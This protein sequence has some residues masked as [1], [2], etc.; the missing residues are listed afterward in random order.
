MKS[1]K[2]FLFSPVRLQ[3]ASRDRHIPD[4]SQVPPPAFPPSFLSNFR[5]KSF[6]GSKYL[7]QQYMPVEL[8]LRRQT[9]P[10][11]FHSRLG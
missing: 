9:D 4:Q 2:S 10:I 5:A 8:Q 7:I 11:Q 3:D 1:S 6:F